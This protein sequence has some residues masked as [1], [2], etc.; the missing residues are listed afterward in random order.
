M[1]TKQ[2][3][4]DC[5][6]NIHV[7]IFSYVW[8]LE[9]RISRKRGDSNGRG[10]S[11]LSQRN[12]SVRNVHAACIRI[13][14]IDYREI[15]RT[16]CCPSILKLLFFRNYKAYSTMRSLFL[17]SRFSPLAFSPFATV[18]STIVFLAMCFLFLPQFVNFYL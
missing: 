9:E 1:F 5:G 2:W 8:S 10:I 13:S 14:N 6:D 18:L 12:L 15:A 7:S 4:R 16:T 3:T 11:L 17:V